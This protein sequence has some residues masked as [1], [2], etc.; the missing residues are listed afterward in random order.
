[1]IF[2]ITVYQKEY[3]KEKYKYT[4]SLSNPEVDWRV[5]RQY[6]VDISIKII[7]ADPCLV[8]QADEM[9]AYAYLVPSHNER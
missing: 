3:I 6:S 2:N 1:M 4:R 7:I 5:F 9:T 8:T